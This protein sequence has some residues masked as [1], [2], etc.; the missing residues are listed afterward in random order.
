MSRQNILR[1]IREICFYFGFFSIILSL[2]FWFNAGS[3]EL[4]SLHKEHESIFIG[5]WAPTF[6]ILSKIFDKMVDKR[7]K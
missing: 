4:T 5:M 2:I 6:F 3:G 7:R 1:L